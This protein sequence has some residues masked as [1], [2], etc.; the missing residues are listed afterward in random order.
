MQQ[1]IETKSAKSRRKTSEFN[2]L[3]FSACRSKEQ[4]LEDCP[5]SQV[6]SKTLKWSYSL[7]D[8][9][10]CHSPV[11][12]MLYGLMERHY[13]KAC[14]SYGYAQETEKCALGLDITTNSNSL[15]DLSKSHWIIGNKHHFTKESI[16]FSAQSEDFVNKWDAP[17]KMCP[18][19][20]GILLPNTSLWMRGSEGRL[21]WG[22]RPRAACFS[23]KDAQ[24]T[25]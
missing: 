9:Y 23:L 19:W 17:E 18:L 12:I 3:C 20:K 25:M 7:Q 16:I 1:Q 14:I 10:N 6:H 21:T 11:P 4:N 8:D 24:V 15:I 2:S 13:G 5:L 22:M